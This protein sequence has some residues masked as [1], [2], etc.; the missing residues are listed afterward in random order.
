M[1]ASLDSAAHSTTEL[2]MPDH[3]AL[4]IPAATLTLADADLHHLM[5]QLAY[6]DNFPYENHLKFLECLVAVH[7]QLL[8]IRK[9]GLAQNPTLLQP[10]AKHLPIQPAV[11]CGYAAL[12]YSCRQNRTIFSQNP[13]EHPAPMAQAAPGSP[14]GHCQVGQPIKKGLVALQ[15]GAGQR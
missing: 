1:T 2:M 15:R 7:E 13:L 8:A 12:G 6:S 14:Q 4:E 9:A 3:P 11:G 5:E 10:Y